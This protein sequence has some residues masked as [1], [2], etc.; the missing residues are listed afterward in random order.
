MSGLRARRSSK[1][2]ATRRRRRRTA[3]QGSERSEDEHGE[4]EGEEA[5]KEV[6]QRDEGSVCGL[7]Q[8][9]FDLLPHG[10]FPLH[11]D[12]GLDRIQVDYG[13]KRSG[14]RQRDTR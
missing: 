6:G 14:Q 2:M 9:E 1:R 4:H 12:A 3:G 8:G 7:A 5:R 13:L 11:F 10:L